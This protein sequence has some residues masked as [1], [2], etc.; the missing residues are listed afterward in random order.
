MRKA[1]RHSTNDLK[2]QDNLAQSYNGSSLPEGTD[3]GGKENSMSEASSGPGSDKAYALYKPLPPKIL[4][5]S[6]FVQLLPRTASPMSNNRV[7]GNLLHMPS[8]MRRKNTTAAKI[9]TVRFL[10]PNHLCRCGPTNER[11]QTPET[12]ANFT[13]RCV[14]QPAHCTA[15][16]ETRHLPSQT[17]R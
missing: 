15:R 6:L 13:E 11:A 17:D 8:T 2:N 9:C 7:H 5:V 14:K 16:M 4:R 12:A 10:T 3:I 1:Q